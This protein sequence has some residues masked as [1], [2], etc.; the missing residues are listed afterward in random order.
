MPLSLQVSATR[1]LFHID[2]LR[3]WVRDSRNRTGLGPLSAD[4]KDF[5]RT[6]ISN[7]LGGIMI[8]CNT[9]FYVYE[10]VWEPGFSADRQS[11][12]TWQNIE[13][14]MTLVALR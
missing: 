8:P 14:P 7:K 5:F 9:I 6:E 4:F 3:L 10:A 1:T 2:Y 13:R 11:L 12:L